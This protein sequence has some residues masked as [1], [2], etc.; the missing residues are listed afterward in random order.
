MVVPHDQIGKSVT[1][2]PIEPLRVRVCVWNSK[3]D[4]E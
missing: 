2:C 4:E 1:W 3:K